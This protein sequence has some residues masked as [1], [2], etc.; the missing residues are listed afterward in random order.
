M[1]RTG[2]TPVEAEDV[3]SEPA[4]ENEAIL[5]ELREF[6][7]SLDACHVVAEHLLPPVSGH[8]V[9]ALR[10][11]QWWAARNHIVDAGFN[12]CRE[13]AAGRPGPAQAWAEFEAGFT[14]WRWCLNAYR[15]HM[16]QLTPEIVALDPTL[17]RTFQWASYDESR[18]VEI[19][20]RVDAFVQRHFEVTLHELVEGTDSPDTDWAGLRQFAAGLELVHEGPQGTEDG[21]VFMRTF[22]E[23]EISTVQLDEG[24]VALL[25]HADTW[26]IVIKQLELLARDRRFEETLT[27]FLWSVRAFAKW[28]PQLPAPAVNDL[29]FRRVFQRAYL[30]VVASNSLHQMVAAR[31]VV[32]GA[33]ALP[34]PTKDDGSSGG[35]SLFEADGTPLPTLHILGTYP[36]NV[37]PPQEHA[38][39]IEGLRQYNDRIDR[40]RQRGVT[41][42][43]RAESEDLLTVCGALRVVVTSC[44]GL[45]GR[46]GE[47]DPA[48]VIQ[49]VLE[50][51]TKQHERATGELKSRG[52]SHEGI[53]RLL[54]GQYWD[55]MVEDYRRLPE[56]YDRMA[57]RHLE[58]CRSAVVNG[59]ERRGTPEAYLHSLEEQ[60]DAEL[61]GAL[62]RLV[63]IRSVFE[64]DTRD[65]ASLG[66]V[67][68]L[69]QV[70]SDLLREIQQLRRS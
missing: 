32:D 55:G 40:I 6:L 48:T 41:R 69:V 51:A 67:T 60:G 17:G 29:Q 63:A 46:L 27:A 68:L 53:E 2:G 49:Q 1:Q 54:K 61:E 19:Y 59:V 45:L 58:A 26:T 44:V 70:A 11:A 5:K 62:Q 16:P 36:V 56:P 18:F 52:I 66:R 23:E 21:G 42:L 9:E 37:G 4:S 65:V 8:D 39:I 20:G 38:T 34:R 47:D 3:T 64:R 10:S 15:T 50:A 24:A 30:V 28:M 31:A 35:I 57:T 7:V 43:K 13:A 25:C 22:S 12:R 14:T 33:M